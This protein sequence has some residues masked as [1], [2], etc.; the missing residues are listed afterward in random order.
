MER[1][2]DKILHGKHHRQ[3]KGSQGVGRHLKD[4]RIDIY[5]FKPGS[6]AATTRY[7]D[8]VLDLDRYVRLYRGAIG[9]GYVFR[10]N[11]AP[12]HRALPVDHSFEMKISSTCSSQF[13]LLVLIPS[14]TCGICSEDGLQLFRTH[15]TPLQMRSP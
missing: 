1:S 10:D 8:E 4:G 2:W 9:P 11:H 3:N 6:V 7:R 14:R 5:I 15:R 13:L 12:H